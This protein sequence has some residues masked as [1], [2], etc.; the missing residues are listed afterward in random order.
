MDGEQSMN[1][2]KLC[3]ILVSIFDSSSFS[4]VTFLL[5]HGMHSAMSIEK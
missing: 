5:V 2:P 1:L 3:E 4:R